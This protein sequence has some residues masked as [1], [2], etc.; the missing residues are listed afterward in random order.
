MDTEN[1]MRRSA[2]NVAVASLLATAVIHTST[3]VTAQTPTRDPVAAEA[4]YN[5]GR[6]LLKKDDWKTACVKFS[7]SMA[8]NPRALTLINVADCSAHEKK[9]TEALVGYKRA[10]ALLNDDGLAP[11]RRHTID[12]L[13]RARLAELEPRLP[14]LRVVVSQAPPGLEVRRDEQVMLPAMF[15]ELIPVDPGAHVIVATA[16]EHQMQKTVVQLAEKETREVEVKLEPRSARPTGISPTPP[17]TAI[18]APSATPQPLRDE[19]APPARPSRRVQTWAW[20][21]GAVGLAFIGAAIPFKIDSA[22]GAAA[23]SVNCGADRLCG[24]EASDTPGY[25]P[26]SDNA[27]KNRGFGAFVGLTVVGAAGVAAGLTG[28]IMTYA[29]KQPTG[30]AG[31]DV[32]PMLSPVCAGTAMQGRF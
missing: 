26:A 30:V 9:L 11:E 25:D 4:L 27:R 2:V 21:S 22:A 8:L 24:N 12:E 13:L 19:D 28:I 20:V 15:G 1:R 7:A 23:V 18:A 14:R 31:I 29:R 5:S 32:V 17:E 10:Q 3:Q 6:D 16:P